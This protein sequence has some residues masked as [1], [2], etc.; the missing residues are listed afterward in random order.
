M[1]AF[2]EIKIGRQSLFE[3]HILDENGESLAAS[4]ARIPMHVI[5]RDRRKI[6]LLYDDDMNVISKAYAYLN[7]EILDSAPNTRAK[8]AYALRLLYC[9]LKMS[10][11]Q[12]DGLDDPLVFELRQFLQ[13][14]GTVSSPYSLLTRRRNNT[15]NEY[16]GVYRDYYSSLGIPCDALFRSRTVSA[17]AYAGGD[18]GRATPLLRYKNN[19]PG[20]DYCRRDVPRY[21]S[22]DEFQALY[23][24]AVESGDSTAQII[25]H[26]MY[27]YGL[28]IGEV[29][30]LTLEDLV[31]KKVG[32]SLAPV[33]VIRN[34][35]SDRS[36]QHAKGRGHVLAEAG[37][38]S[39]AYR[40]SWQEIV[41]DY[42]M[43]D[44]LVDYVNSTHERAMAKYPDNYAS[45]KADVVS[46]RDAPETNHYVF[47]N[48]YGRVLSGQTWGNSLKR[49]FAQAGIQRDWEP[50]RD[51]LSHRFR[52]G[53]AMFHAHFS[54]NPVSAIKLREWMRHKLLSSTMVY[55]NLSLEDEAR[56]KD[57][58]QSDLYSMIP[59]LE[60]GLRVL[61]P[62]SQP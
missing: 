40:D 19:L 55:F 15:V 41:L 48:R 23:R 3:R 31:E 24:L 47:L 2:N 1:H 35:L 9:F 17:R 28:R 18:S 26:L 54:P 59:E 56:L 50:R 32:G 37:Y 60:G 27:G 61:Q 16:F 58:F 25:M 8:A 10:G 22:P 29:L 43:Y 4:R 38:A 45:G 14:L 11:I 21:V 12:E 53:F 20:K 51:N 13:G 42:N 49:Y 7:K 62:P 36:F 39:G 44:K 6:F 57:S 5:E 52:H 46:Q 30:S 34:R 33:L